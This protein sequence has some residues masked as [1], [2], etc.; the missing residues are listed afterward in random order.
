MFETVSGMGLY[1][2]DMLLLDWI[3]LDWIGLVGLVVITWMGSALFSK[4]TQPE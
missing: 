4:L 1:I 2:D 3:G